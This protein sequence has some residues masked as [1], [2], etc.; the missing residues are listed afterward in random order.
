MKAPFV[1][2]SAFDGV[3]RWTQMT[4]GLLGDPQLRLYTRRPRV[5]AASH[6]LAFAVGAGEIPV[7][8][9]CEG[10]PLAGASVT[11]VGEGGGYVAGVTD[12]A[13][14]ATLPWAADHAGSVALTVTARG[15]R[16]YEAALVASGAV[17]VERDD[18]PLGAALDAPTPSPARSEVRVRFS[19]PSTAAG[20]TW[21]LAAFDV[22]GRRVRTLGAGAIVAGRFERPWDLRSDDGTPVA[23]GIYFVRLLAER[24]ALAQRMLVLK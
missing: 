4:L 16:A 12:D 20:A 22:L 9:Q 5:L 2:F 6:P 17:G 10:A 7:E 8:V 14:R 19:L 15:C 21:E 18:A 3:H 11:A 1:A 24:S 13:G 23:N